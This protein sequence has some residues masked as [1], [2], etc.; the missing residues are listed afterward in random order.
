MEKLAY[1][2]HCCTDVEFKIMDEIVNV[3][4]KGMKF[5]YGA[6]VAYC[7]ECER[8]VNVAEISDLNIIRAYKAQKEAL[9][10]GV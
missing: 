7:K 3:D 9:E 1:C 5:S 6:I 2:E 8:E 4:L 10:K